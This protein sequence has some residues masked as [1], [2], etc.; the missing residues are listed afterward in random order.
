[1]AITESPG[2]FL[3]EIV[4]FLASAPSSEE[5]LAYRPSEQIR[6]RASELLQKHRDEGITAEEEQELDQFV[7]AELL[8]QLIKA[9][10]HARR[11]RQ[12]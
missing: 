11:A 1:M 3:D 4:D 2:L 8:L 5:M 10:I 12:P 6:Q 9:R 7:Q